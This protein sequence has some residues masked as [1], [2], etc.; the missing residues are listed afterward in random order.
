M[1]ASDLMT[2]AVRSCSCED[3]LQRAAQIMWESDCGVVPVVDAE[4][5]V[6]GMITDRDVCMAAYIRGIPLWKLPV[7]GVM[8]RKI[9]AVGENDPVDTVE[10]HMRQ[11]QVRRVP[12]VDGDGRLK[13][14]VSMNDLVRHAHRSGARKGDGLN[15][16]RIVQTLAAIC[17][18]RAA[19][20]SKRSA[21]ARTVRL[22]G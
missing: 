18:P 15:G 7:T 9:Y 12:V 17:Q 11:A 20:P 14:I 6:V 3:S 19:A 13:G 10:A 16:D 22:S 1:N 2:A 21:P 5:H 8:A 4:H